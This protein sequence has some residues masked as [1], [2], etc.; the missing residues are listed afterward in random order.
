MRKYKLDVVDVI[1]LK[2]HYIGET[3]EVMVDTV[4]LNEDGSEFFRGITAVRFNR[5]GIFPQ[6]DTLKGI[7]EDK[8]SFMDFASYL[9]RYIKQQVRYL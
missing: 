2:E 8:N 6:I 7:F 5:H 3:K 4:I 1:E 9:K